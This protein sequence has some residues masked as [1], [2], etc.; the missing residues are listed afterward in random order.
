MNNQE[1]LIKYI[2]KIK[3]KNLLTQFISYIFNYQNLT[4]NNYI[5]RIKKQNNQIIMDIYDNISINKLN[6]YIFDYSQSNNFIKKTKKD[7][8]Y[9]T[10]IYMTNTKDSHIRLYKLAYLFTLDKKDMIMYANTFLEKE[11]IEILNKTIK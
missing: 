7:G 1:L 4:K 3:K 10:H 11:F 8:I 9:I 6:T 2:N 5:F